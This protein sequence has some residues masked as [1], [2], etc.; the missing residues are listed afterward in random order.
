MRAEQFI[1]EGASSV[2]YHKTGINAALNIVKSGEFQM[3]SVLGNPSEEAL[4]P[5]GHPYYLSATRTKVGDYHRWVGST[6]AMFVLDGNRIANHYK[7]KPVDY[8]ERSWQ[9][10]PDRTRESEDRI[11]G[12]TNTL[13]IDCVTELHV[14][15]SEQDERHSETVRRLLIA[16][17]TSGITTYLYSDAKAWRLQDTRKAISPKEASDLLKGHRREPPYMKRPNR[18]QGRGQD[19]YGRSSLLM[20]IELLMKKP[21]QPLSKGADKIRYNIQY[22]GDMSGQLKNDFFNAKKPDAPEYP[23]VV[24]LGNYMTKNNLDFTK[25]IDL[26]K[27]KWAKPR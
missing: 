7:V 18:G 16:A 27:H 12:R 4:A 20:W 13:P 19:A 24:K 25:L 2:L 14:L 15:L 10:S 23:L 6:A 22:Y 8:W 11:F 21:G 26:L 17:K 3:S 5:K 1:S 9:H